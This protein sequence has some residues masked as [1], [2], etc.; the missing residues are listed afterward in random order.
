M[1]LRKA[2][3]ALL[4]AAA[5][6]GCSAK[7]SPPPTGGAGGAYV[8]PRTAL[9]RFERRGGARMAAKTL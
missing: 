6:A 1:P 9:S 2:H 4:A 5:L 3:P 8:V 7:D